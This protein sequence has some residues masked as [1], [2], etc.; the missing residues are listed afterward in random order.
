V[1]GASRKFLE[2]SPPRNPQTSLFSCGRVCCC[3][4]TEVD[5]NHAF[6]IASS[7]CSVA[8]MCCVCETAILLAHSEWKCK[9]QWYTIFLFPVD[10]VCHNAT[11]S[12]FGELFFLLY[13]TFISTL[14]FMFL[15]ATRSSDILRL[16][17]AEV[18]TR[19]ARASGC[20]GSGAANSA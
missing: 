20:T 16:E 6:F 11:P 1:W 2:K 3:S 10:A 18:A 14:F 19:S 7:A 17:A 8:R 4:S 12:P 13:R 5:C 15:Q 9:H